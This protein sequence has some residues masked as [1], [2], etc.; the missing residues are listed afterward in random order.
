M[1]SSSE[2]RPAETIAAGRRDATQRIEP[3]LFSERSR[4]RMRQPRRWKRRQQCRL[5]KACPPRVAFSNGP[6]AQYLAQHF[7][8]QKGLQPGAPPE[9]SAI[10]QACDIVLS[11]MEGVSLKI[12]AII[13]RDAHPGKEFALGRDALEAIGRDCL[14]YCGK[15]NRVQMPVIIQVMRGRKPG[16]HGRAKASAA[17]AASFIPLRQGRA[18]R[19]DSGCALFVRLDEPSLQR[20]LDGPPLHRKALTFAADERRRNLPSSRALPSSPS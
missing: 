1:Q 3:Q 10:A 8:A 7:I 14:K 12:I 2:D 9:A 20:P 16:A 15:V 19:L 6:C 4:R 5:R 11:G 18:F 13:D 17:K